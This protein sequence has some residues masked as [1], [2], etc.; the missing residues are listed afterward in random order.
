MPCNF[1]QYLKFKV[2]K[3]EELKK[4]LLDIQSKLDGVYFLNG[5]FVDTALY[6]YINTAINAVHYAVLSVNQYDE[7]YD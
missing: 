7:T 5:L 1:A 2:M 6:A 3:K 4:E